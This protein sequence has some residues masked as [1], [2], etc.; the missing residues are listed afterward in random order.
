M[1]RAAGHQD[2]VKRLLTLDIARKYN[3]IE[4]HL[5]E[6]MRKDISRLKSE[7]MIKPWDW[8]NI[9]KLIL[10]PTIDL[11]ND[12]K[13]LKLQTHHSREWFCL[14]YGESIGIIKHTAWIQNLK[15]I[16]PAFIEY[17]SQQGI[18]I[19]LAEELAKQ[20][21]A[22]MA[23]KGSLAATAKIKGNNQYT[24]RSTAYW[25]RKGMTEQ[26]AK[27]K[28][29]EIQDTRSLKSYRRRHGEYG[30]DAFVQT[31]SKWKISL[32][33]T[34]INKGYWTCPNQKTD[35]ENYKRSVI[36][37]TRQSYISNKD[38]INPYDMKRG[39]GWELDHRYSVSEGFKNNIEPKII[40]HW[41]NLELLDDK[42]NAIKW[43]QCS[44]T[45]EQLLENYE[46]DAKKY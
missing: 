23:Q 30:D 46:A 42:H 33:K 41:S 24:V 21:R 36:N 2:P 26:E 16:S 25:I 3:L 18:D 7:K 5:N 29:Q 9:C 10:K 17:Y 4:D 14:L 8:E 15:S 44:I 19:N 11:Y 6:E 38:K 27:S 28:V 32:K 35:W 13:N 34:M 40:S 43:T 31:I 39:K 12:Y 37:L 20:R 45:V 1:H 22:I